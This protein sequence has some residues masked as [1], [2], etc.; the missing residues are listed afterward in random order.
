MRINTPVG[1]YVRGSQNIILIY[2]TRAYSRHARG[3]TITTYGSLGNRFNQCSSPIKSFSFYST[4][5]V[6]WNLLMIMA[7]NVFT[8][9][10]KFCILHT[11]FVVSHNDIL[12]LHLC[13]PLMC[14]LMYLLMMLTV[15]SINLADCF[16]CTCR[17]CL[18]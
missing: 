13:M 17:D 8:V 14:S 11:Y 9:L 15:V 7:M 16:D 1:T 4:H 2:R 12:P 5:M 10:W 3:L 6:H 18:L